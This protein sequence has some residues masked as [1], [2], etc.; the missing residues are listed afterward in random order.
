MADNYPEVFRFTAS[1]F[2]SK[3]DHVVTSPYNSMFALYE[4]QKNADC[5]FPIDNQALL[6]ICNQ[7]ENPYKGKVPLKAEPT[8]IEENKT[9]IAK[10]SKITDPGVEQKKSKP[11]DKMNTIIAHLL[12]NLTW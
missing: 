3:E 7:I 12:S 10:G 9:N 8:K 5:V 4:L 11:F 2:P 1:V 6:N